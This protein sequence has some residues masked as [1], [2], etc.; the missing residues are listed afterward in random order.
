MSVNSSI[1]E[2]RQIW[3]RA[4][5]NPPPPRAGREL[6]ELGVGWQQQSKTQGGLDRA[7]LEE[8]ASL[9]R[10]IRAGGDP[11]SPQR[12]AELGSGS[13]LVREWNGE[14]Y[15]V[16]VIDSGYLFENRIWRSLSEIARAITGA[17]WNGPKF[18]GLR[19]KEAA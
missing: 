10:D 3:E 2:L 7:T 16:Q 14:T 15:Q 1:G 17:R 4:Y 18:F 5:D 11:V 9:V 19:Q 6:L 8:I 13:T 12:K